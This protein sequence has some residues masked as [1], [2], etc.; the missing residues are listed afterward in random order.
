M[1]IERNSN[2]QVPQPYT[3]YIN[4][5]LW[6]EALGSKGN[7][8]YELEQFFRRYHRGP[9]ELKMAIDNVNTKK[10]DN[11]LQCC[12]ESL[13]FLSKP[14]QK[15]YNYYLEQ[16]LDSSSFERQF[17]QEL[18]VIN[19]QINYTE[20]ELTKYKSFINYFLKFVRNSL[21]LQLKLLPKYIQK[22]DQIVSNIMKKNQNFKEEFEKIKDL[23]KKMEYIYYQKTSNH[24]PYINN[25]VNQITY[26]QKN[27]IDQYKPKNYLVDLSE[28]TMKNQQYTRNGLVDN[29]LNLQQQNYFPNQQYGNIAQ[30]SQQ[31]Q[32][33]FSEFEI[34]LLNPQPQTQQIQHLPQQQQQN[35][36]QQIQQNQYVPQ[37]SKLHSYEPQQSYSYSSTQPNQNAP[38]QSNL[39]QQNQQNQ[40]SPQ[41]QSN[42]YSQSQQNQHEPQQSNSYQ[43]N[44]KDQAQYS[45][46]QYKPKNW[47]Q[48]QE[49][50]VE[51]SQVL[52]QNSNIARQQQNN[53]R[54]YYQRNYVEYEAKE[55]TQLQRQSSNSDQ[56][57]YQ[58]RSQHS[59]NSNQP[60]IENEINGSNLNDS[61]QQQNL[62]INRSSN[63]G[64]Q[65]I[66][67]RNY[68]QD[69]KYYESMKKFYEYKQ[70]NEQRQRPRQMDQAHASYKNCPIEPMIAE[71]DNVPDKN[72][73][74]GGCIFEIPFGKPFLSTE[75]FLNNH[76][77]IL[78]EDYLKSFRLVV[79]QLK[80]N[81][82]E[83]IGYDVLQ[84]AFL[85][86][87][88]L[89]ENITVTNRGFQFIATM[90]AYDPRNERINWQKSTRLM[91]GS[92]LLL[93][94][95]TLE[96]ML[97]GTVVEKPKS[98]QN[99]RVSIAIILISLSMKEQLRFVNSLLSQEQQ[100][101]AIENKIYFE[102]YTHF[103][104]CLQ[105]IEPSQFPF[106]KQIVFGSNVM[107][108]PGYLDNQQ[109][110]NEG[111]VY[112][113][114]LKFDLHQQKRIGQLQRV[115]ILREWPNINTESLDPSQLKA[116][117]S[118]LKNGISLIQGPPGTG[119]TF[120]GALGVRIL[121][122]N[123]FKWNQNYKYQ[124][125]PILIVC[126][127]NHAL[128][129]F[130]SHIL[131]FCNMD[132]I[133]RIG[134]RCKVKEFEPMLLT[135][136]QTSRKI[137]FNWRDFL[138][139]RDD[140]DRKLRNLLNLID[141]VIY[142]DVQQYMPD[143]MDR[144]ITQYLET[145]DLNFK[146]PISSESQKI[147]MHM[148][149]DNFKPQEKQVQDIIAIENQCGNFLLKQQ[150][151][152]KRF[153]PI[154][155]Y[156]FSDLE[157]QFHLTDEAQQQLE[158]EDED[159]F[160]DENENLD[161][162]EEENRKILINQDSKGSDDFIQKLI[163]DTRTIKRLLNRLSKD[164]EV[165][166]QIIM[167]EIN[168]NRNFNIWELSQTKRNVIT[169]F[170]FSQKF[171]YLFKIMEEDVE[172]YEQYI[173]QLKQAYID[174]DIRF[175][176]NK[177]IVGVTLTGCAKYAEKLSN[178]KFN[179]LIV[180]EAGEVLESNL[181]AVLSQ[182]INHLI[183]I[184]DHQQLKP[185]MECYDLEVKFRANISLFERLIKNGLE[186]V[187]L[188]FQ[189]RMKSKFADFIRLIYKDYQDHSTIQEQNKI[190]IEGLTTDLLLFD[191]MHQEDKKVSSSSKQNKFE[192]RMIVKLVDYL[193]K[194][195][196]QGKQI[197]I[198]TTYVRQALYIQK[199][200]DRNVRVQPID[201][202]QGEENDIILLSLVRSNDDYK[203]GFVAIDNRVCVAFSRARLGLFVFGD[204]G[205]IKECIKDYQKKDPQK[206]NPDVSDLWL[207]ILDL[208]KQKGVIQ[209]SIDLKCSSHNYVTKIYEE[210]DWDLVKGGGCTNTCN[211]NFPCGHICKKICHKSAH[212]QYD[213]P[214][215]CEKQL[216][217]GHQCTG[218]CRQIPCPP[219][220]TRIKIQIK[221]CGHETYITC[222]EQNKKIEC[223]ERCNKKLMCGHQCS[224]KCMDDCNNNRCFEKIKYK[225][226]ICKHETTISCDD[227]NYIEKLVC[228]ENCQ[229][230]LICGH[231]CS[232]KCGLCFEKFHQPCQEKCNKT[233]LCG[234]KC[235]LLCSSECYKC[236]DQCQI[237]CNC[238]IRCK[239]KCSEIC[240]PCVKKCQLKCQHTQCTKE[241]SEICDR[242][243]CNFQCDKK[244]KCG[245]NCMGFCGEVCP[246]ICQ[247]NEH[248]TQSADKNTIYYKLECQCNG[249]LEAEFLDQ[250]FNSQQQNLIHC[251]KCNQIIWRSSRY[252]EQVKN[253][254]IQFNN[255]KENKLMKYF[256]SYEKIDKTYKLAEERLQ[257]K[258]KKNQKDN[259]SF[260]D[261]II[262]ELKQQIQLINQRKVAKIQYQYFRC[263][264]RQLKYYEKTVELMNSFNDN[265]LF[266]IHKHNLIKEYLMSED[267]RN[268]YSKSFWWKVTQKLETL[269]L[270]Q[271][272]IVKYQNTKDIAFQNISY[273]IEDSNFFLDE[274]KKQ[275][276]ELFLNDPIQ[277]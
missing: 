256:I 128:D 200:C 161:S 60:Y 22:L 144:V 203:L 132:D 66:P 120:C 99:G 78:R 24:Q 217:C 270:Y 129:Q 44:Q 247:V 34:F 39:Y 242:K 258:K 67:L 19:R 207:K 182:Q 155:I 63:Q 239:K 159:D 206:R 9:Q 195:G 146:K 204:F 103:L 153:K 267:F 37:Q 237:E 228:T 135:Y 271:E 6:E 55:P 57:P 246:E 85:Y 196:Y 81:G 241:C 199:Q 16:I 269:L 231:N 14:N 89:I 273:A 187:T 72:F 92:L 45:N 51:K 84:S 21:E 243:P 142:K 219:C 208:A 202:Y 40:L 30:N 102:T 53:Q 156:K 141:N 230:Q 253:S 216:T 179:I 255:E 178:L 130:L 124:N 4:Q 162:D 139:L 119:K 28:D 165:S 172:I 79:A 254:L 210:R 181:V 88:V 154:M 42:S 1:Y 5:K 98:A 259:N 33:N 157:K 131:T 250:Y 114:D 209:N 223:Q 118:I 163:N 80:K 54:Q 235:S 62:S 201:N 113:I 248:D 205:F 158:Q 220:K 74:Y 226:I 268:S 151:N 186:Y 143:L 71:F 86:Y 244:L 236:E 96:Y 160:I 48:Q 189:R 101:I 148:W 221:E 105:M 123:Q 264:K 27:N 177:K 149:L 222:S 173:Q 225:M 140:L 170:I 13:V 133:V 224:L 122:Q 70:R 180:E 211:A 249:I 109:T 214:E 90:N 23:Q 46:Q 169:R 167:E 50:W 17:D 52:E 56:Q 115:N 77:F 261:N 166:F 68:N 110:R 238:Q 29:N 11:I 69:V 117:Q 137:H 171:Q 12:L 107:P 15:F 32:N 26:Q 190:H 188:R 134:G 184:G 127:T 272:S 59:Y 64:S 65:N 147:I 164:N 245:C 212:S 94:T 194:N 35:S 215:Q 192:A 2:I 150:I 41:Q 233:L 275:T 7:Q 175:I 95:T 213:C 10:F 106:A 193:L 87:N 277:N 152:R 49:I 61:Q 100:L 252:Q 183:L 234:H 276:F 3:K 274:T 197:T 266:Q 97:F 145:E 174:R 263:I 8:A 126:Q 191:H 47:M 58:Q 227:I 104:S 83:Q 43:Q 111:I 38:Q 76:F 185:H 20:S 232:G 93:S 75:L 138:E 229:N 91:P 176:Q 125:K 251:P 218:S 116:I 82:F 121:L 136:N 262:Q 240:N 265:K 257:F 198:L 31:D 112:D 168:K 25:N 36:Y 73:V 18:D 260:L 108:L